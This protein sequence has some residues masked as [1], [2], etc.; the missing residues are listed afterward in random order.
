VLGI[1]FQQYLRDTKPFMSSDQVSGLQKDGFSVGA[2]SIDHPHYAELSLE[3][4]IRQT[5]ES[6][7][8]LVSRFAL[9]NRLFAFPFG[10]KGAGD[11]FYASAIQDIRVDAIFGTGGWFHDSNRRLVNRVTLDG[12]RPPAR[13]H[14]AQT[15][16]LSWLRSIGS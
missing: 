11:R 16:G 3:E 7:G 8:Q 5:K 1:D 9:R 4:Q 2:H 10:A 13:E 14:L 6:V 15:L 12:D